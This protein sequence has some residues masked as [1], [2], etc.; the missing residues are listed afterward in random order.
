MVNGNNAVAKEINSPEK[1]K[2]RVNI[3]SPVTKLISQKYAITKE[4][5]ARSRKKS[6][7][8]SK[9]NESVLNNKNQI[10]ALKRSLGNFFS[11]FPIKKHILEFQKKTPEY[12]NFMSEWYCTGGITDFVKELNSKYLI[13]TKKFLFPLDL[14]T[15]VLNPNYSTPEVLTYLPANYNDI[16]Q[17]V[18]ICHIVNHFLVVSLTRNGSVEVFSSMVVKAREK[19]VIESVALFFMEH[20]NFSFENSDVVYR[21][22]YQQRDGSSCGFITCIW[23]HEWENIGNW[24]TTTNLSPA[25]I[26]YFRQHFSAFS[27]YLAERH[28]RQEKLLSKSLNLK[29]KLLKTGQVKSLMK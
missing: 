14:V 2:L 28:R 7:R 15:Y 25:L 19:K 9:K 10:N 27:T 24:S 18:G 23:V 16:D 4:V 6:R 17:F 22:C 1:K 8:K 13:G 20:K 26:F 5:N 21:D 29:L 11:S 12:K 3:D